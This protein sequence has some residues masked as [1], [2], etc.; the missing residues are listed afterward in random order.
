[1]KVV[2]YS[3][4]SSPARTGRVDGRAGKREWC[5]PGGTSLARAVTSCA[6]RK[7]RDVE[8]EFK[9]EELVEAGAAEK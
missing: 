5:G 9:A 6:L 8:E 7:R 2:R 4:A 1:M 3:L